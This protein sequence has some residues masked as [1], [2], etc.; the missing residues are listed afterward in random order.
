MRRCFFLIAAL[1]WVPPASAQKTPKVDSLLVR[2]TKPK[3]EVMDL[4]LAAFM[5]AGLSITDQ[6]ASLVTADLGSNENFVGIRFAR[7]IHALLL[8]R[9]SV[10]TVLITGDETRFD[11]QNDR[12]FKRLRIDNKAGGDGG[13]A[14]RKMVAAA[15]L[16]DSTQVSPDAKPKP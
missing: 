11:H 16:L 12:Q 4:V 10:T 2:I 15:M 1:A 6:T 3:A 7:V 13:K 5:Q 14:W 9:D 8:G